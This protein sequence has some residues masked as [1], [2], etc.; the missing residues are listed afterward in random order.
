MPLHY[1][2]SHGCGGEKSRWHQVSSVQHVP[3]ERA[4][5]Y[6]FDSPGGTKETTW[7]K[8]KAHYLHFPKV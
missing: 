5:D 4:Q 3:R 1:I 2:A 8:K 7:I 6:V